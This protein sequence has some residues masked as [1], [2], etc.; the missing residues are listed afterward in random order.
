[1]ISITSASA[2]DNGS[3]TY[4]QDRA[5][6][7]AGSGTHDTCAVFD[8]HGTHG[9]EVAMW[10]VELLAAADKENKSLVFSEVQAT[11]RERLRTVRVYEQ[12][13]G[14]YHANGLP[15]RGGTTA[16][17]LRIDRMTGSITC[18]SVGDSEVRYYDEANEG[19]SLC[20]DH[21]ATNPEEYARVLAFCAEQTSGRG[22]PRF[23]YDTQG[24][25]LSA[26]SRCPFV[27]SADGITWEPNPVGGFF[28]CDIRGNYGA[29]IHTPTD[30]EGLAMTRALGDFNMSRYGVSQEPHVV[31]VPAPTEV[32]QVVRAVVWASD[33]M[34]DLVPPADVGALVRREDLLGNPEAASA[35]LLELTKERTRAAFGGAL[36]DNITVGV[37]YITY[38]PAPITDMTSVGLE[39]AVSRFGSLGYLLCAHA[40]REGE[41]EECE[42]EM[43][44]KPPG[45]GILF[46]A[47]R[48]TQRYIYRAQDS[49]YWEVVYFHGVATG[50]L[51]WYIRDDSPLAPAPADM[52]FLLSGSPFTQGSLL[53]GLDIDNIPFDEE[54]TIWDAAV[55]ANVMD[56]SLTLPPM[57]PTCLWQRAGSPAEREAILASLE[58]NHPL[59][60]D[61]HRD[62]VLTNPLRPTFRRSRNT[63]RSYGLFAPSCS[64]CRIGADEEASDATEDAE[65]QVCTEWLNLQVNRLVTASIAG[66]SATGRREEVECGIF[67]LEACDAW[68]SVGDPDVMRSATDA[69]AAD[70]AAADIRRAMTII[71][72]TKDILKA[73]TSRLRSLAVRQPLVAG[74]AVYK[75]AMDFLAANP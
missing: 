55:A 39:S 57:D 53:A 20:G 73:A 12:Q 43:V 69:L 47:R 16:S 3:Y 59:H 56:V 74:Y 54:G 72:E 62:Q 42:R 63:A 29:Y 26:E 70:D 2:T 35:A 45:T 31:T 28:H 68:A 37:T 50:A 66:L 36:G 44:G 4:N 6:V 61:L 30:N 22:I 19:V 52:A 27:R 49:S 7:G 15:V 67:R 18:T 9:E 10:C 13:E 48:S 41:R 17:I 23:A 14:L 65:L 24:G 21:S 33:G 40:E 8:G 11:L 58:A 64:G 60:C 75:T 38:P 34:W 25:R 32:N 51:Q 1:M 71:T 5:H 46:S